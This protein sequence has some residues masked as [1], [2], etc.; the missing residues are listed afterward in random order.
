V[1]DINSAEAAYK[2]SPSPENK[3]ALVDL[4]TKFKTQS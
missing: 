3:K 1:A 4:I 2:K